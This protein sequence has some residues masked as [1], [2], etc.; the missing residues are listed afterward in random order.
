MRTT[1]KNVIR[2]HQE[3]RINLCKP[4]KIIYQKRKGCINHPT[5][6]FYTEY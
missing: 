4:Y 1:F 5:D 3:Q 2:L 6:R